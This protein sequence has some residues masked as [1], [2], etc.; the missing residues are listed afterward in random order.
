VSKRPGLARLRRQDAFAAL[1]QSRHVHDTLAAFSRATGLPAKLAMTKPSAAPVILGQA[2]TPFCDL[3][4]KSRK[5]RDACCAVWTRLQSRLT[6]G[7]V[8]CR[9]Q[10]FAG[11]TE[12]AVPIMVDGE[13]A[14]MLLCGQVFL[15][16]RPRQ[17]FAR[18]VGELRR[19]GIKLDPKIARETYW[20]TPVTSAAELRAVA[21][22]LNIV[23]KDLADSASHWLLAQRPAEPPCV[24][25]AKSFAQAHFSE[26]VRTRDVAQAVHL[27]E[28]HFCRV[29]KSVTGI[30][31]TEY[32]ARCRVENAKQTLRN[33][34]L[35][36]TDTAFACGFQSITDFDRIF[37]RYVGR[38]PR[39]YRSTRPLRP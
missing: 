22:L 5:G 6:R 36:I 11:L 21:R 10:C 33:S 16:K 18:I 32:L 29:F 13:C 15:E 31:F 26:P 19:L 35:R 37:K 9:V 38:S 30:T 28:Q 27:S 23:A 34:S 12:L 39:E 24:I 17:K 25:R 7:H 20:K 3:L 8:P 4:G 2:S 1:M 14:G